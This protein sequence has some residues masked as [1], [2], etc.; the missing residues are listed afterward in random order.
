MAANDSELELNLKAPETQLSSCWVTQLTR[1]LVQL[2]LDPYVD[3][4]GLGRNVD[5]FIY[6]LEKINVIWPAALHAWYRL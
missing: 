3:V 5:K 2:D 6:N 1:E 4:G